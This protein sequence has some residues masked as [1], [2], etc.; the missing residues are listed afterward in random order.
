MGTHSCGSCPAEIPKVSASTT[1]A[2][3]NKIIYEVRY[4]LWFIYALKIAYLDKYVGLAMQELSQLDRT[5]SGRN[6]LTWFKMVG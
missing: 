6:Q 5:I 4:V 3:E 1:H 2:A